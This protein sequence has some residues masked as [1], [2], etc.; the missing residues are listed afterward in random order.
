MLWLAEYICL[1]YVFDRDLK[2]TVA[3]RVYDG[4]GKEV[5]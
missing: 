3:V 5:I 2:R 4:M 1:D